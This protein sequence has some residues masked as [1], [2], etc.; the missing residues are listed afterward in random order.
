MTALGSTLRAALLRLAALAAALLATSCTHHSAGPG[1]TVA[2]EP[3]DDLLPR[4]VIDQIARETERTRQLRMREPIEVTTMTQDEIR[5]LVQ[6]EIGESDLARAQA[7]MRAFGFIPPDLDLEQQL[8]DLYSQEV[9]GMYN[10][11]LNALVVLRSVA[12]GLDE[13]STAS[14]EARMVLAHEITH[15]L[16]DQ[17]FETLDRSDEEAWSDDAESVLSCLAEGDATLTMFVGAIPPN[18][19]MDPTLSPS[20]RQFLR[21]QGDA[22]L[23]QSDALAGAP[24]YFGHVLAAIYLEGAAFAADLR[25]LGGWRAVDEAHRTPP[26]GTRDVLHTGAYL[27]GRRIFEIDFPDELPGLE[28]QAWERVAEATLGELETSAYLLDLRDANR[29]RAAAEGWA[30]DYF[31]VYR[32]RE[33]GDRLMLLWRLSFED[34]AEAAEFVAAAVAS[35][36]AA[37]RGPCAQ[38]GAEAT[39]LCQGG[40]DV[41]ASRGAD[42]VVLRDA[43]LDATAALTASLFAIQA[44]PRE[45]VPPQPDLLERWLAEEAAQ[46]GQD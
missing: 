33:S 2:A 39:H 26:R 17:N 12:A 34:A 15:A 28:P 25:R 14:L 21:A 4:Q 5:A 13:S 42:V 37:G 1:S 38:P 46:A 41:I 22:A 23:P 30:G 7:I 36:I 43:P 20:F 32:S 3:D 24:R 8:V 35:E 45:A 27:T 44:V 40:A 19:P 6:R 16:Q 9:L 10:P 29:A 18:A 31:A 11:R